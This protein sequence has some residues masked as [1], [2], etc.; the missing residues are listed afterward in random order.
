MTT[1][2]EETRVG[3][4]SKLTPDTHERIIS[5]IR[6]G[7]YVDTAARFAGVHPSTVWRWWSEGGEDEA[8]PAK[9]EFREAVERARAEA[10]VR[11]VAATVKD[12]MGGVLVK[13]TTRTRP[14]GTEEVEEQ[15]TPPNGKVALDYLW[16]TS[17]ARWGRRSNVE[18]TGVDGGPIQIEQSATVRSLAARLHQQL[19]GGEDV[20]PVD[21]E[22]VEGE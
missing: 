20:E 21:A 17:P 16:R 12:A 2:S 6:A 5:A 3:R 4:R 10:E 14:D 22:I 11:M 18:L 15:F 8:E 7:N 13:K 9:R 1:H 19:S